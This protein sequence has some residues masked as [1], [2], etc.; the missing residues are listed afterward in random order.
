MTDHTEKA[1]RESGAASSDWPGPE[2]SR[3]VPSERIRVRMKG[4]PS[5]A[6]SG[7]N[8]PEAN[9]WMRAKSSSLSSRWMQEIIR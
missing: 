9:A 7:R 8:A 1:W 4:S 6:W 2:G 5:D 3:A